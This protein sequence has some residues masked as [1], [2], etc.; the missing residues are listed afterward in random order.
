[1]RP[2]CSLWVLLAHGDQELSRCLSLRFGQMNY[3]NPT[4]VSEK[5]AYSSVVRHHHHGSRV[6]GRSGASS[7]V[8]C[9]MD[10]ALVEQA[11]I[12]N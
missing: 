1:M 2:S 4:R 3:T 8:A 6:L 7:L 10:L 11:P 5:V 9:R 12:P